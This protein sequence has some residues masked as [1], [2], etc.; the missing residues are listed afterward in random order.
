MM[1]GATGLSPL[2]KRM[3]SRPCRKMRFGTSLSAKAVGLALLFKAATS[4]QIR[5][6]A[7]AV[8]GSPF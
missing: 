5:A 3:G 1:P 8:I 7:P 6:S 4:T 2:A